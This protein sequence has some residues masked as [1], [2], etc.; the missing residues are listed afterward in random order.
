MAVHRPSRTQE[1]ARE[2]NEIFQK[3]GKFKASVTYDETVERQKGYMSLKEG[4]VVHVVTDTLQPGD[5]NSVDSQ[6]VYAC[7]GSRHGNLRKLVETIILDV[8][9]IKRSASS[10]LAGSAI[11]AEVCTGD[12]VAV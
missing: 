4:D 11:V 7:I 6:Y 5:Q 10:E 9:N 2:R 8:V 3:G 1:P 12:H